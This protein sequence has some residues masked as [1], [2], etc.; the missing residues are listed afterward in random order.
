MANSPSFLLLT[1]NLFF[2]AL[3][4]PSLAAGASEDRRLFW[5][6]TTTRG[7]CRGSVAECIAGNEF[8]MDSEI[9]RRILDVT[10]YI[11]YDSLLRNNVPCSKR[12]MS[13]Y[14]N[15]EEGAEAN[16]YDRGCSAIARCRS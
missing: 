13:Y 10:K 11:S 5:E 15:C 12:G 1:I 3:N 4:V 6:P 9:N 14:S 7:G 16:P 2:M 8:D